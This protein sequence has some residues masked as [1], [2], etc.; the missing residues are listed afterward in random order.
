[1]PTFIILHHARIYGYPDASAIAIGQHADNSGR[2]LAIGNLDQLQAEFPNAA[3]EDMQGRV[4]WPGLTDAHLHLRQYAHS[5]RLLDCNAATRADCL[6]R[7]AARAASTAPGAWILG[8]GWR[9]NDWPEGFGTAELLDTAAPN[10]PVYLTNSSLH[11]GWANS[12]AFEIAGVSA[13]TADPDNGQLQRES[14]GQPTGILFEAAMQL[15]EK[16]IPEPSEAEDIEAISAAQQ[17]L[18]GFGL[19]GV[20]DFDRIRSFR[21][22]QTLHERG[23]LKLRVLKNLPV[24]SLDVIA[25][26]GLRAGFGDD[27]L[28]IGA[29]KMFADGALGPRTAAM[30]DPYAGEPDN[31]GMLFLDSEQIVEFGQLAARAGFAITVHAIGD[32]ANHEVLNAIEQMR[33]FEKQEGLPARRH[34]IEHAQVLHP[35]DLTRLGHLG[36]IA[37]MQ[38]LHATAD[39]LAADKYWG[40]RTQYSYAWKTQIQSGATLAFG[41]DAPVESP[42]PFLGLHAAITRRRADGSPNE[43]GWRP[44]Q[45][46][47]LQEALEGF[48]IGPA[49]AAGMEDR[50]GRLAPGYFADLILLEQDPFRLDPHELRNIT[51]LA[52]MVG[53]EWVWRR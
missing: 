34:R 35:H 24:E 1:M 28:R 3:P 32:R 50:L 46:L 41:S 9:Q 45:R 15:V 26:V 19:T 16:V 31:R 6:E 5:L 10:N 48:T 12:A 49:Y 23:D 47:T 7:V 38:P 22:L 43:D 18:W 14:N 25:Q 52:T 40:G 29:I 2:I 42:N 44:E 30:I 20:H 17:R 53:G 33:N 39:M 36:V 4:I 51:P 8:H 21:A 37:S 13:Q 11:A 27:M